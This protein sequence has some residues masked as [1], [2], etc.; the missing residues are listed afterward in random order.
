MIDALA[1]SEGLRSL[2]RSRA[3]AA[4]D[5]TVAYLRQEKMFDG[6]QVGLVDIGW[7][8]AASASLVRIAATQETQVRC[9]FAGGLCG[10]E[11]LAAPEDSR[12]YLIDSRGEEPELRRALVHLL[13]TF[14]AGSGGSTLG[15]QQSQGRWVPRLARE[16][17]NPAMSWGLQDYQA[18]VRGYV[19]AACR[20]IGKYQLT[21]TRDDTT[22]LRPQPHR[23]PARALVP[24]D[25]TGS[26]GVGKLPFEGDTG[27]EVLGPVATAR[28]LMSYVAHFRN[29]QKRP[30]FGPWNQAVIAR[31]EDRPDGGSRAPGTARRNCGDRA[32]LLAR[33]RCVVI[34]RP[35][36]SRSRVTSMC[37]TARSPY[38][39]R[40][41]CP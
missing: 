12:A 15:Y 19:S 21:I 27:S 30:R 26:R 7:H 32:M 41:H 10:R 9:Y 39:A 38:S 8:G 16:N 23:Q 4:H 13:E 35:V 36:D 33:V 34:S 2:A 29:A 1:G 31:T 18:L 22:A 17:T 37:E 25:P 11:S 28:D 24:P 6:G 14:C 3:S 20:F 40:P 5:A